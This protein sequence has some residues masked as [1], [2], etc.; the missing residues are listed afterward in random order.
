MISDPPRLLFDVEWSEPLDQQV[1]K[2]AAEMDDRLGTQFGR[3]GADKVV[4]LS[5]LGIRT[6]VPQFY[7]HSG[8]F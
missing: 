7:R 3:E 6:N 1:R 2:I 4:Q 8:D 5:L